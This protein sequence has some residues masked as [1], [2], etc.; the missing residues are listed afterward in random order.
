VSAAPRRIAV[1]RHGIVIN[2]WFMEPLARSL[3]R[4]G[5][6]VRNRSYPT[7][8]KYIEEHALDLARELRGIVQ[9]E[10]ARGGPFE[11]YLVTHSLGGLV[12]RY[13]LTHLDVPAIR[14]AVQTVPP[15]RG[16][17]TARYFREFFLYR[18]VF[19]RKSGAQL[20]QD[21][22][23]IYRECGVPRNVDTGIIA[24]V[25]G[26]GLF[27]VGLPK[28][29]DGIVALEEARLDDFPLKELPYNHTPILFRRALHDEVARFLE[30]G[31]FS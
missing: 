5:F 3:R 2:R 16:S 29:H 13:A 30:E 21:P 11:L 20:A 24:G 10:T 4:R 26:W 1:F 28:P 15:N 19:G 25:N 18:W 14:R 12:M 31:R 6:D 22:P 23:G 8:R 27:P 17:A 7:T 9:D